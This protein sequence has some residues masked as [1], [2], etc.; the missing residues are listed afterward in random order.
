MERNR[1]NEMYKPQISLG[2]LL[3]RAVQPIPRICSHWAIKSMR[4]Q[5]RVKD[6][7]AGRTLK[8]AKPPFPLACSRRFVPCRVPCR[9]ATPTCIH[10]EWIP[11][12]TSFYCLQIVTAQLCAVM[13]SIFARSHL[14]RNL[15]LGDD[16]LPKKGMSWSP[17]PYHLTGRDYKRIYVVRTNIFPVPS[18]I[19]NIWNGLLRFCNFTKWSGFMVYYLQGWS[20][21]IFTTLPKRE[22]A[23]VRWKESGWWK[24]ERYICESRSRLESGNAVFGLVGCLHTSR[25]TFRVRPRLSRRECDLRPGVGAE[26]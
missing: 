22:E 9:E 14:T 8:I 7:A 4:G 10:L 20:F 24:Q 6:F 21:G 23:V 19:P 11:P 17:I 26:S 15:N 2:F 5:Q 12:C 3:A 25:G 1:E 13:Q 18:A 16:T